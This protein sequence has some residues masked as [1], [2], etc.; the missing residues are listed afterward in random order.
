MVDS[1]ASDN[2]ID[3][4][5]IS[6]RDAEPLDHPI[7]LELFDGTET[8]TGAITHCIYI[9]VFFST[10]LQQ[11]IRFLITPLHPASKIVLGLPWLQATNPPIDWPSLTIDLLSSESSEGAALRASICRALAVEDDD[12]FEP[13]RD[14]SI[15]DPIPDPSPESKPRPDIKIIG[16]AS[17]DL[18]RRQGAHCFMMHTHEFQDLPS[19]QSLQEPPEMAT[20]DEEEA[21]AFRRAVPPAYHEFAD[22]FSKAE[23]EALPP[24]RPYDHSIELEDGQTP[25][26]KGVY[27]MS[28][29]ELATLR[30]YLE[31]QLGKGFIRPSNSPIGAPVL[32]AKKKDGSLR[33][34]VDYRGLNAITRRNRY[35]LPLISDLLDRLRGAKIYTK[36]DL[37][38]GYNNVRIREGDEWKTAFRTRYGS[39]EYLVMPFG[40]SNAPATFQTFMNDIFADMADKFVVVYLDDILIFSKNPRDHEKHVKLVLQ[41][42]RDHNLHARLDK[43]TFHTTSIEYLGFIVTPD[44]LSMDPEKTKVI[45]EWPIPQTMRDVQSFLGFANFY[46][47]FIDNYSKIVVPLTRLT[48][49]DVPFLWDEAANQA[50]E[51][52]KT[53]FTTAPVLVHF[54]PA[55]PIVVECDSSDYAMGLILSQYCPP[56][57]ELHPV[58]FH[59][60]ALNPAER[61]YEIYDKEL[62][63]IVEAFRHWRHYLEGAQ[64]Q[65]LVLTDHRGL[66]YFREKNV[67]T[68]R[69]ARWSQDLEEQWFVIDYRTGRLSEKPDALTRRSD[70][71]PRGADGGYALNNPHNHKVLL[72]PSQLL[73]NVILDSVVIAEQIKQGLTSDPYARQRIRDASSESPPTSKHRFELNPD[74]F[75]LCDGSIYV[76]DSLDLRL[77][78]TRVFHDH[79]LAGHPGVAKTIKQLCRRYWWPQMNDFVKRYVAS[80]SECRR[81]KSTH[82]KPYGP[83]RFLPIPERPWNSISM[84]FIEGL[85]D[86]EGFDC[87]LV[88]VDRLTKMA[89]FVP[90]VKTLDT[91]GL[92]NI[93]LREIFALHG[94]P[95]DI[96]S[97]RGKHFVSR[98]WA[99]LMQLLHIKSNLSTAYHPETDGQTERVNQILEQYLRVY[100]NYQ[101]D[102]W[103][104]LLPLAEFAYN[105]TPHSATQLSPFFANKGYHPKLTVHQENVTSVEAAQA[106]VSLESLH[107]YLRD[108]LKISIDRYKSAT[109]DRRKEIPLLEPD[110]LCWLDARNI[111]T[112]RPMKKLDHKRLGPYRILEKV[113]TH[114]RRLQLPPGLRSIHPVFHVSLLEPYTPNTIPNRVDIPPPPVEVDGDLEFEVEEI[115]DSSVDSRL[116][117]DHGLKYKIRWVGYGP[118]H[119]SWHFASNV[120]NADELLEDFHSRYPNKPGPL[121]VLEQLAQKPKP[122]KKKPTPKPK[123]QPIIPPPTRTTRTTRSRS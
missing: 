70:V 12:I 105:N 23:A 25:P 49:K 39:Y 97:D 88:V 55:N 20:L 101:Q 104:S 80:C 1:G 76:P 122:K 56:D 114:A 115:L 36:I 75:L 52:L 98:F 77:L 41:R 44:G 63:V 2:F 37:R 72:Q 3:P 62:N 17:F 113:S 79:P 35:P 117:T 18:L 54:D 73:S 59:S 102:D 116:K 100:V 51:T 120:E 7:V 107:Q 89:R 11:L 45:R 67:L 16:A 60:R 4:S 68:R 47:R 118:E 78:V 24:H 94:T 119:D 110:D 99:S 38:A 123:K 91:P 71:Y 90:T 27:S 15:P 93:F 14:T 34:C 46:R 83:L 65:V 87:I 86:S 96:V 95:E 106:A 82:H 8:K 109:E 103:V 5:L 111:K 92:A 19:S 22:V 84:D 26:S 53:S 57:N 108:Q 40:M 32:F 21:E 28:E 121:S 30:E 29:Y 64:H 61:N 31:D 66:K 33:L 81:A 85:P 69:Q 48:R 10:G 43:T 42:L 13:P 74:G 6:I 112:K 9:P 50:F 58:A